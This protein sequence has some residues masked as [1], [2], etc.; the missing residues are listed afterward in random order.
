MARA[1][2]GSDGRNMI[3]LAHISLNQKTE[4]DWARNKTGL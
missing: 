2:C 1:A 4:R 3:L